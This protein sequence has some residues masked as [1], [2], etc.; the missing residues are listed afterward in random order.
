[1]GKRR[2]GGSDEREILEKKEGKMGTKVWEVLLEEGFGRRI[3]GGLTVLGVFRWEKEGTRDL[4]EG[5]FEGREESFWGG[6][7]KERRRETFG[8]RG[9][10]MRKRGDGED[11]VGLFKE[12]NG[13][14]VINFGFIIFNRNHVKLHKFC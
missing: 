12:E 8:N 5:D 6:K 9:S 11:E 1:M 7:R 3:W 14:P 10:G 13:L 2:N 4:K